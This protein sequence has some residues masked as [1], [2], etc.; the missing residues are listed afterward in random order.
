VS[1]SAASSIKWFTSVAD[2][3]GDGSG[4]RMRVRCRGQ[5]SAT[6]GEGGAR[7]E[8]AALHEANSKCIC[9]RNNSFLCEYFADVYA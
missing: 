2:L 4:T 3:A 7:V 9:L 1:C 6:I 8:V 5:R